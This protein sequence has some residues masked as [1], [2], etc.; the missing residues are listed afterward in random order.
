[1]NKEKEK[2]KQRQERNKEKNKEVFLNP[3]KI[4]LAAIQSNRKLR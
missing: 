2:K 1:M 4:K 3:T